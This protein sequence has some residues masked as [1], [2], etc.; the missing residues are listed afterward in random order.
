MSGINEQQAVAKPQPKLK[1]TYFNIE[2]AAERVRLALVLAGLPFEDE[3]IQFPQWVEMK[4]TSKYGQLPLLTVN[5]GA[6]IPQSLAMMMVAVDHA[7][8]LFPQ[9][10]KERLKVTEVLGLAGDFEKS[11][12]PS[13]YIGMRPT[14][15]GYEEGSQGTTAGKE[16]T[17]KLRQTFVAGDLKKFLG[18]YTNLLNETGAFFCGDKPTLA[19]CYILPQLRAFQKGH[20][21]HV[22]TDCLEDFPVVKQWIARMMAVPQVKE[23]YEKRSKIEAMAKAAEPIPTKKSLSNSTALMTAAA[24]GAVSW[25]LGAAAAA[26]LVITR[27]ITKRN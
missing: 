27:L 4:K 20:I 7:E 8:F 24:V 21:D 1:L 12:T 5:D 22:P 14:I 19:D 17:K 23:W 13:L 16:R 25:K 2:G 6:A 11:W 9:N 15:F 10:L 18:Y 26:L 3:R